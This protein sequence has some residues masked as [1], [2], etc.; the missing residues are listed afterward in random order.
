MWPFKKKDTLALERDL[1]LPKDELALPKEENYDKLAKPGETLGIE[2]KAFEAQK[3]SQPTIDQQQK[4]QS[5][6]LQIISAKLDTIKS[7]LELT[8]QRLNALEKHDEEK[9]KKK[10]W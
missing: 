10:L 5:H 2:Q 9:A 4:T 8:N 6:D 1:A 3:I 7:M